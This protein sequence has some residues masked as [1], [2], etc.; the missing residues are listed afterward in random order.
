MAT[1]APSATAQAQD[2]ANAS[3]AS[4]ASYN[5]KNT[6]I[7]EGSGVKLSDQQ[8]VANYRPQLFEGNP[9]LKHLSLWSRNATFAD[10]ITNAVGY[11][12]FA[13]QWYGLPAVFNPIKI[14][15]HQVTSG[16]NPI[17]LSLSNK[18]VVKGI[19]KEQVMDSVVKIHV[20]S[21]GKIEKVE[22]KWNG[23]LPE[24]GISEVRWL[25]FEI[26]RVVVGVGLDWGWW[27]FCAASWWWPFLAF[28]KLNA[29]TVPTMVKVPKTEEEDRKMQAER[30][31]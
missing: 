1:G 20:G 30:G 31:N 4:F 24:G 9:T 13:A 26:V 5:I 7:N 27:A 18:Y 10:N 16:G 11:D 15:S 29:V 28:R 21:D 25:P 3:A 2:Q 23:K 14:Q 8:K 22:D 6:S 12:K 19:K 17:E